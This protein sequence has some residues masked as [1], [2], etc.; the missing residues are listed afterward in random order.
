MVPKSNSKAIQLL[1]ISLMDIKRRKLILEKRI[2]IKKKTL[3]VNST[4]PNR[5]PKVTTNDILFTSNIVGG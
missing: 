3:S 2:L 4:T 5:Y 1:Q